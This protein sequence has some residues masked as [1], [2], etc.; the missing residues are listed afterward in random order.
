MATEFITIKDE[1]DP[2]DDWPDGR[3]EIVTV[4]TG[5]LAEKLRA[6]HGREGQVEVHQY[7]VEGGYSEYT[8]EW[9]WEAWLTIGGER[10]GPTGSDYSSIDLPPR[11]RL[12][13]RV[14]SLTRHLLD[15]GAA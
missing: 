11:A 12:S 9:D 2:G 5:D 13:W 3:H 7:G 15:V 1:H 10:I 8:V 4:V 14:D 6:H